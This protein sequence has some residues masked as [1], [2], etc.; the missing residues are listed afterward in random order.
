MY[1]STLV[2][3]HYLILDPRNNFIWS[4]STLG[5]S[6]VLPEAHVH[7]GLSGGLGTL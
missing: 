3:F 1:V 7:G 6:Q 4:P 2:C 5:V